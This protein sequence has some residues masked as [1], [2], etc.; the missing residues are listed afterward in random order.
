[1]ALAVHAPIGML[2]GMQ[3]TPT[4][5]LIPNSLYIRLTATQTTGQYQLVHETCHVDE[6]GDESI[7]AVP[8]SRCETSEPPAV[9]GE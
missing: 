2:R 7:T 6:T 8:D 4:N 1:M 9:D 5:V 3:A